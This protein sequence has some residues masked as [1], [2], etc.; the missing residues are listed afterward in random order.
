M[1]KSIVNKL[2]VLLLGLSVVV[3]GGHCA[4]AEEIDAEKMHTQL[5][6][7]FEKLDTDQDKYVSIPEAVANVFLLE[8]FYEL[9]QDQDKRISI[10]EFLHLKSDLPQLSRI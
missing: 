10:R 3:S 8:L 6:S 7:V 5:L 1:M 9:D 2:A 4:A